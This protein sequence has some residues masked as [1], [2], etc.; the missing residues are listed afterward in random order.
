MIKKLKI[1]KKIELVDRGLG[2]EIFSGIVN[3]IGAALALAGM[4]LCIVFAA[5]Q[6]GAKILLCSIFYGLVLF[7]TY[8]SSCLYHSLAYNNGKRVF[9]AL[10]I[11]GVDLLFT[12]GIAIFALTLLTGKKELLFVL[13]S[14]GISAISILA[15]IVNF[16]KFKYVRIFG[17]LLQTLLGLATLWFALP[18]L[19]HM[20][21]VL[22]LVSVLSFIAG[23]TFHIF[24]YQLSYL[25][26]VGHIIT[27]NGN[28][29]LFFTILLYV[30]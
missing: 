8:L 24:G 20:A 22:M 23:F 14:F 30:I 19:P 3:G 6:P 9:R 13:G 17:F 15:N 29:F 28:V 21:F 18:L 2:A 5:K 10:T 25:N 7:L 4:I 1:D 26:S 16:E 11:S 27:L 12:A